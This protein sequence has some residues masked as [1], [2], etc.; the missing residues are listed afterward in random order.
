MVCLM[1]LRGLDVEAV[2]LVA[3][4]CVAAEPDLPLLPGRE[5]LLNAKFRCALGGTAALMAGASGRPCF[6]SALSLWMSRMS[7]F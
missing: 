5:G 4:P 1:H 7:S 6:A 2:C 3:V